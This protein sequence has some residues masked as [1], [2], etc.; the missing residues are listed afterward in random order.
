M[1]VLWHV[2]M[3][4]VPVSYVWHGAELLITNH[5]SAIV[6]TVFRMEVVTLVTGHLALAGTGTL[7]SMGGYSY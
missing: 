6:M 7:W 3:A 4:A 1:L 5:N 2:L